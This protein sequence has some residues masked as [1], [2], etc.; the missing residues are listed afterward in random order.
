M[1]KLITLTKT[2]LVLAGLCV[3]VN[4]WAET[5]IFTEDFS[6]STYNVTWGGTKAGGVSPNVVNGVLTVANGSQS[7]DRSAYVAFGANAYTGCCRLTF[8][9]AMTKSGWNDKNNNFY[10]LPS[11]TTDRYPSTANAALIITQASDGAITAAGESVGTT[12]NGTMLTYDLYLNTISGEAKLIIKK[13]ESEV[14][15]ITYATTATGISTLHLTFNK[16]Y[17]AFAIDNISF[18]SLV[19]PSF[20]LSSSAEVV[21]IGG[22]TTVDVSDITGTISVSSDNESAATASYENGTVTITGVAS[23]VA[24]IKV[25]AT[26]DGLE[27]S[28]TIAV[29]VG[30]VAKTTVTV[31]YLCG[32]TPIADPLLITDVAI[33]SNLTAADITYDA[34]IYGEGVRYVNPELDQTL[35]YTVVENGVINVLYTSQAAVTNIK[36]IVKIGDDEFS[37]T[38]VALE[39]KYVGDVIQLPYSFYILRDGSL[40]SK[41]ANSSTYSQSFTLTE[42]DQE[43]VFVY[44]ATAI[45]NVVYFSEGEDI[46]GATATSAGNNMPA[47]S[48]NQQ[49]GYAP[50]D[51]TLINLPSGTYQATI[52]YYSNSSAGIKLYFN[53]GGMDYTAEY[54]KASNWVT[55]TKEFGISKASDIIWKTS[56]DSKNG[57][58]FIYIQKIA[59]PQTATIGAA[60]YATFS[61][62][63]K[64]LD[65]T[66]TDV[67]AYTASLNSDNTVLLTPV[68]Q[69][70]A[71]T[72]LVLAG[73]QGTYD[74]PV[75]T[76]ATAITDNLL[77]PSA[78]EVIAAS[79]D[80]LHHYVLAKRDDNVGFYNL[81]TAKNI[82]AGK[83]YLE[84]TVALATTTGSRVAWIFADGTTGIKTTNL[85]NDTNETIY[86]LNGQR[87]A[88]PQKG[89]YI[90][91]GKKVIMK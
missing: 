57:I 21:S 4:A 50:S 85:T 54:S 41:A 10:I 73:A 74:I 67:K 58:D 86:N 25:K 42:N 38:N 5:Q 32:E 66:N 16:N 90:V 83:A 51:I 84:T 7:G 55:E 79:T 6:G 60:G 23:G 49:C 22:T 31:N 68:K 19:P 52:V 80:A 26:N 30:E 18:Y 13:G 62:G 76:E 91:N 48:S 63:D 47:R 28:Q 20:T 75:I 2:L 53:L 14:K 15:T 88:A 70:P 77:K 1:K 3:G 8:D 69:V 65:F 81:A 37:N 89:L 82:G 87:V 45:N 11:A 71:N 29:T 9:M 35:P 27:T 43:C 46:D 17:G 40:Y 56:G 33:G 12:Y 24:N 39:G 61:C 64:A 44:S 72:G 36:K 34:I 78:D 59:D